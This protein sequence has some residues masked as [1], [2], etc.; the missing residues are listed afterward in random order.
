MV[1][2][3]EFESDCSRS[4][5]ARIC[6]G[7]AVTVI[8][9]GVASVFG[10]GSTANS[11][12]RVELPREEHLRTDS[13]RSLADADAVEVRLRAIGRQNDG[14]ARRDTEAEAQVVPEPDATV[15]FVGTGV[16]QIDADAA[17]AEAETERERPV[18][19]GLGVILRR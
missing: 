4:C 18:G 6:R 3:H 7:I 5:H 8:A 12:A 16:V 10:I 2:L 15:V 11:S 9:V 1:A 13:P 14:P 19:E 17:D